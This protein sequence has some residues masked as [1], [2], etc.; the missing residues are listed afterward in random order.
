MGISEF[1]AH[2]SK[3]RWLR[4]LQQASEVEALL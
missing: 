4:D 3:D 2:F 1:I